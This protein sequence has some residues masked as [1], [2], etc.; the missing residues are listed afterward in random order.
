MVEEEA[1]TSESEGDDDNDG[2]EEEELRKEYLDKELEES[3]IN[4]NIISPKCNE[5]LYTSTLNDDIYL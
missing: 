1:Q 3:G 4:N 2:G 5:E